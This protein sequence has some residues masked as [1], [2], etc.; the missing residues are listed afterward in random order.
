MVNMT[1]ALGI[2]LLT[3]VLWVMGA[4]LHWH[5]IRRQEKLIARLRR[6]PARRAPRRA[7]PAEAVALP[8]RPDGLDESLRR[9][10][11]WTVG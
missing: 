1:W 7:E 3:G 9:S 10:K 11:R 8:E 5:N 6:M 4:V 2:A